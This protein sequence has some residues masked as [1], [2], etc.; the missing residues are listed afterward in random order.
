MTNVR[1][2]FGN[3]KKHIYLS[4]GS[5]FNVSNPISASVGGSANYDTRCT[6]RVLILDRSNSAVTSD[7]SSL[8]V[9]GNPA[10][11]I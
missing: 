9:E 11:D 6:Y 3:I 10:C 8:W 1:Q 5:S 7:R 2:F 4:L